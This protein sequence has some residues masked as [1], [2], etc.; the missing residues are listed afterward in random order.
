MFS[1]EDKL[2][3]IVISSLLGI[4]SFALCAIILLIAAAAVVCSVEDPQK[5]AS[6]AGVPVLL[7]SSLCGGIVSALFSNGHSA[8]LISGVATVIGVFLISLFLGESS[9]GTALRIVYLASVML[10]FFSGGAL[11]KYLHSKQ[12]RRSIRR[13]RS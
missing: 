12:K 8:S 9:I 4:A 6:F 7:L 10:C 1:N 2:K 11:T 5:A 3:S 13:R